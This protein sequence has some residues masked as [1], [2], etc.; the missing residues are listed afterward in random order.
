M[1]QMKIF[2]A[3]LIT[4]SA[5]SSFAETLPL[6][7]LSY[8]KDGIVLEHKPTHFKTKFRF[9]VQNRFTYETESD[10]E[11][12]AKV[13]GFEVRRMR[14]RLEGNVL[15]PRLLYK[16]QLSFTRGDMDYD[17]TQYPNILRDAVVGWKLSDATTLWY[18][19]TKLP[20]NRQRVV[21][22]GAQQ[23]VDR[24]LV[25]ATF[26]LDRDVGAQVHHQ[27][28]QEKPLWIKIAISN[29]DGRA[30]DNKD[31]GLAYTSRIEWLPL[32]TFKDEGDYFEAD[33][34]R[35]T[36]P[37]ISFGAVYSK[38]KKATRPGGQIGTQYTTKGLGQD[39]ETWFADFLLKYRGLSW[40]T[41]YAR[42]WTG[43]AVFKDGTK[44]VAIYKGEGVNTQIGYVFENNIEPAIR[45]TKLWA[46]KETL[47][48]ENDRNQ[49]AVALSKYFNRHTVKVQTDLTYDEQRN[50]VNDIYD[51][52]WIYRLQLEIGI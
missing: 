43:D 36:E 33:L 45:L 13:A 44:D 51:N 22:S 28:G 14:L 32:G 2:L 23:F 1:G 24:S 35:E 40:S 9:R 37:N 26:N 41:E 52:A 25:N 21:S 38:N 7:T 17:R 4:L 29:G 16:L 34:A 12:K 27:I 11:L 39:L 3:T 48:V 20:G 18:G 46:R 5:V 30:T 6:E 15:D 10:K 42:R 19:Q 8:Y 31:N 49:Y 47:S 50:R